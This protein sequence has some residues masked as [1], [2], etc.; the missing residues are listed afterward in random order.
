VDIYADFERGIKL[1]GGF[2][3]NL[4][5]LILDKL[6]KMPMLKPIISKVLSTF[7]IKK[8]E[9]LMKAST[10]D[11]GGELEVDCLVM[12]KRIAFKIAASF[13][14]EAVAEA[15][16]KKIYEEI[17]ELAVDVYAEA[18]EVAGAA[19]SETKDA[20]NKGADEVWKGMKTL[21][22]TLKHGGHSFNTCINDC[23]PS[24]ANRGG[25][26][27]YATAEQAVRSFADKVLPKLQKVTGKDAN[28]TRALRAQTVK[29]SYDRLLAE[30]DGKF[31]SLKDDKEVRK[32]FTMGGSK[33]KGEKKYEGMIQEYWDNYRRFANEQ[34]NKLIG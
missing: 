12:G 19:Y 24:Y 14:P 16:A 18:K 17:K 27:M 31:K 10:S 33:D 1:A 32:F 20:V 13:D 15:C 28:E 8:A 21:A 3:S 22:T 6:N 23:V 30:I 26:K 5:K 2:D 25:E 11:F 7:S 9:V 34:Y 4:N 29:E